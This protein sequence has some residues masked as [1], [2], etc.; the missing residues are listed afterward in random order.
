MKMFSNT[1]HARVLG[2]NPVDY[3]QAIRPHR[4]YRV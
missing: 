1:L 4:L 2:I 3:N